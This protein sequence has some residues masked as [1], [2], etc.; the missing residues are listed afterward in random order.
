[1]AATKP[2]D[3]TPAGTW[4]GTTLLIYGSASATSLSAYTHVH[5]RVI[6]GSY[7]IRNN[8]DARLFEDSVTMKGKHD[9]V[10]T[11]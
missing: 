8:A 11:A 10:F 6:I 9:G 2:R 3:L 1:M 5:Q 7:E 4:V